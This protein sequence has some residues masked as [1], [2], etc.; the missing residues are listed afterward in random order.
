MNLKKHGDRWDAMGDMDAMWAVLS[1][2]DKKHNKWEINAFFETGKKQ[3]EALIKKLEGIPS[4]INY[5]RALDFGCGLGRLTRGLSY[6]FDECV[7][8]DI[9]ENMIL[10]ARK[11]N[12]DRSN[13]RFVKNSSDDLK[14]FS[15]DTFSFIFSLIVL[16]H[17]PSKVII[18][19]YIQEFVR[20]LQPSGILVF[21][22]PS[23][24]PLIKRIQP[25][26]RLYNFL[27]SMGVNPK[28]LYNHLGLHPISMRAIHEEEVVAFL[29]QLG[30][31]ILKVEPDGYAGKYIQSRTYYVMK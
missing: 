5:E 17:M 27:S 30:A 16:Q 7:G 19:K 25:K 2:G 24:I 4:S 9:S 11:F 13:C 15:D 31:K 12:N 1:G 6:Y 28:L 3:I 14:I 26:R 22:L 10:K 29:E 23:H 20:C 8:V 21:Q 18:K